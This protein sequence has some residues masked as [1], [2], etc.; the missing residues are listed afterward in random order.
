MYFIVLIGLG[1]Q[2]I[3]S[4]TVGIRLMGLAR[5]S[6]RFP[7]LALSLETLLM[8][9]LGYPSLML[10]VGLE[11]LGLP[12]VA[13]VFFVAMSVIN[14]A[15]LMNYFFTWR[16]FRPDETWA[17]IVCGLAT[18]LLLAPIGGL[19]VHIG[20]AGINAG[21]QH[22]RSW[23]FPIV[24]TGLSGMGWTSVESFRYF[25][26]SRRRLRLG[27][28]D[29]AVCNR[30][31]LWALASGG[32]LSVAVLAGFLLVLGVN[33]L[34]YAFFTLYVGVTGLMNSVCMMLCF[35]PPERY[36]EWLRRR[37][38]ALQGT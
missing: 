36:L 34:S 35:M 22:A 17:G 2:A 20:L 26:S 24:L 15:G 18:W 33:P 3:V 8:P 28:A 21:I 19:A 25:L 14:L 9:A 10:S 29:A 23:T 38:A 7:E 32:W 31:L 12:G 6:R 30:F 27:L 1:L 5:R 37:A 4:L 13:P 16:V 11:R